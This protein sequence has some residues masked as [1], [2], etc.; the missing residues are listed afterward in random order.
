MRKSPIRKNREPPPA[1]RA[2]LR[3][4]SSQ[5]QPS[6][7]P[8]LT[9]GL[10]PC[11]RECPRCGGVGCKECRRQRS[12]LE[13]YGYE[14]DDQIGA[15][16]PGELNLEAD[17]DGPAPRFE[18]D[19]DIVDDDDPPSR[20]KETEDESFARRLAMGVSMLADGD[21]SILDD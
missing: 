8:T 6:R 1:W 11:L 4:K 17:G 14:P 12:A 15:H 13:Y 21:D 10:A 2:F 5:F 16:E 9:D 20:R 19:E 3:R 7:F 18:D